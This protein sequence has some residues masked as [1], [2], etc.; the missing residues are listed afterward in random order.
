MQ[1]VNKKP[2]CD[3]NNVICMWLA[4]KSTEFKRELFYIILPATERG[5]VCASV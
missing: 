1:Y 5:L 3:Y 2:F 4:P